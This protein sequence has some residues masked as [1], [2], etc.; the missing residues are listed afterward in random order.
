MRHRPS[1]RADPSCAGATAPA[2]RGFDGECG[3]GQVYPATDPADA[4]GAIT[5]HLLSV[6]STAFAAVLMIRPACD[7]RVLN[8]VAARGDADPGAII[9][10]MILL[11]RWM[12]AG[13][14][15]AGHWRLLTPGLTWIPITVVL[16]RSLSALSALTASSMVALRPGL[17]TPV[18]LRM[19]AEGDRGHDRRRTPR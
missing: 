14:R 11:R 16:E 7:F 9:L 18:C 5:A 15:R 6:S 17:T 1:P 4:R 3:A 12:A 10:P 2:A 19:A 8:V 13:L